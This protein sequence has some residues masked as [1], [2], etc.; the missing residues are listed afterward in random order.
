MELNECS[1]E[2]GGHTMVVLESKLWHQVESH[3]M[4]VCEM[5]GHGAHV[6]CYRVKWAVMAHM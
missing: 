5:I 1:H 6:I 4:P 3:Y 2:F